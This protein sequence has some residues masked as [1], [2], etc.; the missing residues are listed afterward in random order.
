MVSRIRLLTESDLEFAGQLRKLAGWNQL[1]VDW[2]RFLTLEPEGCFL[3]ET[4]GR[5]AGTATTT[6]YGA[7]AL[8]WIGMVLVHPD[9]RRR[10]IGTELLKHCI[11]YLKEER[12]I[13]SMKLD[14]TPEGAPLYEKLGFRAEWGLRRWLSKSRA[15]SL[16]NR[17]PT[18]SSV[19]SLSPGALK[20]DQTVFGADRSALLA[21]LAGGALAFADHG[22]HG[23]GL[24]RDG[25]R[26]L[27]LGPVTAAG[28]GSGEAM[29]RELIRRLP[30]DRP[31]FWD[32]PDDNGSAVALAQNLGFEPVRSLTRM[33]TGANETPGDPCRIW[34]LADP[35]F[36]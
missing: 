11:R 9:F 22:E 4:E 26:A 1:P 7:G 33:W 12:L 10:G 6:C 30:A 23:F 20:L 16:R 25:A 17:F 14:A 18:E 21:S 15:A 32:I 5:R 34:A 3:A 8:A 2:A 35:A 36:G 13:P 27:Y 31:L 29:V 28:A 19:F 24:S